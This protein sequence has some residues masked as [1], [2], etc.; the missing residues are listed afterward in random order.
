VVDRAYT[1]ADLDAAIAAITDPE[2]LREAQDLVMRAAP[3]LQR[4]LAAALT[5][6][7]W[8][9][10]GHDQALREATGLGDLGERARAVHTLLAEETRMGMLVG[11]AV[12]FGLAR[13]LARAST[14]A[15]GSTKQGGLIDDGSTVPGPREL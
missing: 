3:S 9:D 6:G 14:S 4:V 8:F 10:A 13:E 2:R 7:G 1:D 11:V 15:A 12:G 5:E